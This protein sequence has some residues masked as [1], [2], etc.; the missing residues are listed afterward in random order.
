[1]H[2]HHNRDNPSPLAATDHARPPS[3]SSS[4][5]TP[6]PTPP[7]TRP[8]PP[9]RID[10]PPSPASTS[11]AL[12]SDP[13]LSDVSSLHPSEENDD[14]VDVED[15]NQRDLSASAWTDIGD[16]IEGGSS[17]RGGG[18]HSRRQS[19]SSYGYSSGRSR[20]GDEDTSSSERGGDAGGRRGAT[21]KESTNADEYDDDEDD[22]NLAESY[23]D[24]EPSLHS[25]PTLTDTSAE[26]S[27][28]AAT[29]GQA[30]TN[31][32]SSS[33]NTTTLE[34]SPQTNAFAF[35]HS[36]VSEFN[37]PDPSTVAS[38]FSSGQGSQHSFRRSNS[39]PAT[40]NNSNPAAVVGGTRMGPG[41]LYRPRGERAG[42][43]YARGNGRRMKSDG[44]VSSSSLAFTNS[45]TVASTPPSTS[46]VVRSYSHN[47]SGVS[48]A[49][50]LLPEQP[51]LHQPPSESTNLVVGPLTSLPPRIHVVYLGLSPSQHSYNP[52]VK[53]I[54]NLLDSSLPEGHAAV[55]A[56]LK[57]YDLL[58]GTRSSRMIGDL[59][60]PFKKERRS[61]G[62]S[63]ASK[64]REREV[65]VCK[66]EVGDLTVE[67]TD[68]S[69]ALDLIKS[70][71]NS[72]LLLRPTSFLFLLF[73]PAQSPIASSP[74]SSTKPMVDLIETHFYEHHHSVRFVP[75]VLPAGGGFGDYS[76]EKDALTVH[77]VL[78]LR[79]QE[80]A[81]TL[82][83]R[84]LADGL[85]EARKE[86]IEEPILEVK[87]NAKRLKR[88]VPK[89][90]LA[91]CT[92]P[93]L[94][95]SV[96]L[97]LGSLPDRFDPLFNSLSSNS[98]PAHSSLAHSSVPSLPVTS[99]S[100]SP[101]II[102]ERVLA[103]ILKQVV[104]NGRPSTEHVTVASPRSA[105][106]S[107]SSPPPEPSPASTS[108]PSNR[109]LS[110]RKVG[111]V[112]IADTL[113]KAVSIFVDKVPKAE[114]GT[115]AISSSLSSS[116]SSISTKKR[117][118]VSDS[119]L[120]DISTKVLSELDASASILVPNT[121]GPRAKKS[122]PSCKDTVAASSNNTS[123]SPSTGDVSDTEAARRSRTSLL[124]RL[125]P[126]LASFESLATHFTIDLLELVRSTANSFLNLFPDSFTSLLQDLE[127]LVQRVRRVLHCL[128]QGSSSVADA[129]QSTVTRVQRG[130]RIEEEAR[131][132]ALQAL[133]GEASKI[134][135]EGL[136]AS[137]RKVE[138]VTE[139]VGVVVKAA[140]KGVAKATKDAREGGKVMVDG[141]L[142]KPSRGLHRVVRDAKAVV[143]GATK[144]PPPPSKE[145][146]EKRE[147]MK[148]AKKEGP[149]S[150]CLETEGGKGKG[151]AKGGVRSHSRV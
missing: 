65:E 16:E 14:A 5:P 25:D 144:G 63:A 77:E 2:H 26:R 31:S 150:P 12:E 51:L 82:F 7:T 42:A 111:E 37:Y 23:V 143:G 6:T 110:V 41:V 117:L 50:P 69:D 28:A 142:R 126:T 125:K 130:L 68:E 8:P 45:E 88:E 133:F 124:P 73:Q 132:R 35:A 1:M 115:V 29:I 128:R 72:L 49:S 71:L 38:S 94:V 18:N 47:P 33:V 75:V 113:A 108:T 19:S 44:I 99:S 93:I 114:E 53:T 148:G 66:I 39:T 122:S 102:N 119:S 80:G 92:L 103:D 120:V 17:L 36:P 46:P 79:G 60:E 58:G 4:S 34:N 52:L 104:G 87:F 70:H 95:G 100:T 32:L 138:E 20:D 9:Q 121:N 139:E 59:R 10:T 136:A 81:E 27:S 62:A 149:G 135:E 64:K 105:A 84:V 134:A 146:L 3:S 145:W 61:S 56:L 107:I 83:G 67:E 141:A 24:L 123:S 96:L 54:L 106:A 109:A 137:K 140:R 112:A 86:K 40:S 55:P 57:E 13:D 101:A 89:Y 76:S 85:A 15:P 97:A 43:A 131:R 127:P 30:S 129:A 90:L 74:R 116:E 118:G 11:T 48:F 22:F 98:R 21:R 151:R 78:E 91:I 147:K